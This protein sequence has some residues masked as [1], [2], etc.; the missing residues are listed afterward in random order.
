MSRN[1]RASEISVGS[2]IG[3]GVVIYIHPLRR[4]YVVETTI[5]LTGETYR[6]ARWFFENDEQEELA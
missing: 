1:K 2:K 6:E 4:Y 5:E 3:S